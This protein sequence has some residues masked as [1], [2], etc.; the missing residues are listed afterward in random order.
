M[1]VNESLVAGL[2]NWPE[3]NRK[4]AI[5]FDL[6]N[7]CDLMRGNIKESYFEKTFHNRKTIKIN[8]ETRMK[9]S[10]FSPML[11]LPN[12]D[13]ANKK[14]ED[15]CVQFLEDVKQDHQIVPELETLLHDPE[16]FTHIYFMHCVLPDIEYFEDIME[17]IGASRSHNISPLTREIE[18]YICRTITKSNEDLT[19]VKKM[20]LIAEA[21]ELPVLKMMCSGIIADSI[22]DECG[23][24]GIHDEP[25]TT[26][27]IN[28]ISQE[29]REIAQQ[30]SFIEPESAAAEDE[31]NDMLVNTLV[32][33]LKSL[34]R[35]MRRVSV[36]KS[37]KSSNSSRSTSP[38]GCNESTAT[39]N[40]QP[41]PMATAT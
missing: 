41:A 33:E 27:Q 22:V 29:M 26:A 16:V 11:Y 25:A 19:F 23:G 24:V 38:C 30:I 10:I 34:A 18:R 31:D 14:L 3:R 8:Y 39:A 2:V 20:L 28:A 6:T 1:H 12:V 32:Q 37:I 13:G 9:T 21:N 40:E 7:V 35:S 17:V 36:S 4:A 5:Q 15:A